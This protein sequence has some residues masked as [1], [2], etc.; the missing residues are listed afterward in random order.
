MFAGAWRYIPAFA[1]GYGLGA[2]ALHY[3]REF[4][5]ERDAVFRQYVKLHPEDFQPKGK[6]ISLTPREWI[7]FINNKSTKLIFIIVL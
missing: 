7:F 4:L 2:I 3:R 1:V 6:T 5:A